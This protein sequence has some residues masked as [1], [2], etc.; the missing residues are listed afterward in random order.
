MKKSFEAIVIGGGHAG[1]EATFAIA[2]KNH[3]VLLITLDKNRIA[4]MPCNPSIGGPAKGILTRE[5]D[6]IGGVQGYYSDKAMIQIKM[7]NQSKGPAVRALRAQIDKL[8][9]SKLILEDLL[10]HPHITIL[11]AE[12]DEIISQNNQIKGV[13]ANNKIIETNKVIVTTGTYLKAF[14]FKGNEKKNEGPSG[15]KSANNL[16]ISLKKLGFTMQRLKTGTPP[17]IFASS[18]DFSQVEKEI[19]PLNDFSFSNRSNLKLKDQVS[20]YLTYTNQETHKIINE[21]IKKS[22]LYSGLIDGIGPRYCPSIEDKVL[23]F[24][25]KERHQI[26]YEPE[27]IDGSIIYV[28][29]LSTSMPSSVQDKIIRTLPGMKNAKVSK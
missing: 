4:S 17:R 24:S 23:R 6:A 7:L 5:I 1:V 14:V 15:Q 16:S 3:N 21:N 29:G 11:E 20:C 2:N 9:Y 26:F 10:N 28:N 18:I 12:V 19:L 8:K 22:S 27:T 25:H 13:K